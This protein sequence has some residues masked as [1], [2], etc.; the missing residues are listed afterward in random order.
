LER[1]ISVPAG[2]RVG[3]PESPTP[4]ASSWPGGDDAVMIDS[5]MMQAGPVRIPT[6]NMV[7]GLI[8]L[9]NHALLLS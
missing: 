2:W 5:A 8:Y 3:Q 7:S 4:A 9:F 6:P 1:V